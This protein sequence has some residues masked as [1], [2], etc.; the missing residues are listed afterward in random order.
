MS[1]VEWGLH[2]V[3]NYMKEKTMKII[4]DMNNYTNETIINVEIIA[5]AVIGG[6]ALLYGGKAVLNYC[7]K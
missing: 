5:A 4:E 1:V 2:T 3:L 6:G 7:A